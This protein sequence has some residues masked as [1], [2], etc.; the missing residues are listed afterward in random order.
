ML[1]AEDFKHKEFIKLQN[2]LNELY[3]KMKKLP[4]IKL[5]KPYQ[6]GWVIFYDV[7]EDIKRRLDYPTIKE[8]VEEAY[9]ESYT[10]DIKV[11]RAIRRKEGNGLIKN[12]WGS[13]QSVSSYYPHRRLYSEKEY[14]ITKTLNKFLELDTSSEAYRKFGRKAYYCAFPHY[15]LV[16]KVKPNIITHKKS[17]GGEIESEY[18]NIRKRL[19]WSGEFISF[20]INYGKSYPSHKDRTKIRGSIRKFINGDADDIYSEKIPLE[21]EY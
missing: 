8:A 16:I 5:D 13:I 14:E 12:K 21:Y 17:K 15:W 7:R 3:E 2:R 9:Y 6:R 18:E 4:N 19:Y 1:N 10:N 11:V 20:Q